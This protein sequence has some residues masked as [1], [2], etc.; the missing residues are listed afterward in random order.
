VARP[1]LT[2]R[3]DEGLRDGHCLILVVA[4]AGH[5]KTTVVSHSL[6]NTGIPSAWLLLD[7]GDNDP[8]RFFTYVIATVQALDPKVGWSPLDTFRTM[9]QSPEALAYPLMNDL[10]A[11]NRPISLPLDD[12]HVITAGLVQEA[13]ALVL[14][15]APL[16]LH[17]VVLTR[18]DPPFPLPRLRMRD[19][20]T[21]IRDRDLRFPPEEMTAFLNT[22]HRLNLPAEQI[23]ALESRTEGWPAGL[24]LAALSVQ[25]AEDVVGFICALAASID[26][27]ASQRCARPAS[28]S[29]KPASAAVSGVTRA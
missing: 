10:A 14:D 24:Q 3:L 5:G 1:R 28:F 11:A 9:P 7:E 25:G 4:P 13:M 26:G 20:M 22:L 6:G 18:A 2:Q 15:H 29:R 19:L 17:L 16:N 8:V 12:Y 27:M 23:A 21:E